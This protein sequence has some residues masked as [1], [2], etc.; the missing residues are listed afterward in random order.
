LTATAAIGALLRIEDLAPR[1]DLAGSLDDR[2]RFAGRFVKAA[3]PSIDVR[4]HQ[5]AEASQ[6]L[7]G[8]LAAPPLTARGG[9]VQSRKIPLS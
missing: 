2:V 7:L 5:P 8:M 4:L 1:L 9:Q 3:E 6:M